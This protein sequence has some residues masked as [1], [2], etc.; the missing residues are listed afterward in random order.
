[1][2]K[3]QRT[4]INSVAGWDDS[5]VSMAGTTHFSMAIGTILS[6]DGMTP[7]TV[8]VITDGMI[9]GITGIG[10]ITEPTIH[11]SMVAIIHGGIVIT[12]MDGIPGIMDM[13]A[14]HTVA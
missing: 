1:M 12:T 3:I 10:D 7:I 6:G 9:L 2:N 5:T 13:V 14:S 4:N 8:G 11:G